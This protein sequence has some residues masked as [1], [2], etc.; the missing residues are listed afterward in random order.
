MPL[1][2]QARIY[3][4]IRHRHNHKTYKNSVDEE[5]ALVKFVQV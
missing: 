5:I 2:L 4:S 1:T 3:M